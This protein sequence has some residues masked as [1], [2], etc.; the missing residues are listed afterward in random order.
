MYSICLPLNSLCVGFVYKTVFGGLKWGFLLLFF[1]FLCGGVFL[2]VENWFIK[3]YPCVKI[4]C[5]CLTHTKLGET[6]LAPRKSK[7]WVNTSLTAASVFLHGRQ[8]SR[9]T[10]F[11]LFLFRNKTITQWIGGWWF[12]FSPFLEER[13]G[14]IVLLWYR[15]TSTSLLSKCAFPLSCS[16]LFW[17]ARD[18]HEGRPLLCWGLL[19]W[20]H[21]PFIFICM[22]DSR[23]T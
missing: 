22:D 23:L 15:N 12:F 19:Q 2:N 7:G 16:G 13:L 21:F 14:I 20:S 3:C 8:M 6:A 17:T 5:V 18:W 9:D 4:S 10:F 11:F 1:F